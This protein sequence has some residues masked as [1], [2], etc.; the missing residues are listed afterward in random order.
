MKKIA[1]IFLALAMSFALVTPAFAANLSSAEQ[2]VFDK[3]KTEL[4]TWKDRAQLDDKHINQY[5]TEAQS[6]LTALDLSDE[7]CNEF[8]GAIDKI[9]NLLDKA[10]PT[11]RHE[12]WQHYT[13]I[14]NII[15]EIGAK[16]YNLHV[17]VDANT[18]KATVTYDTGG[19]PSTA[20]TTNRTVKQTGFGLGQTIA[21]A[22]VSL[23]VLGGAYVVARKKQLFNA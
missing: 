1:A 18:K 23:A 12:L 11:T 20:A 13:E 19:K 14:A 4:A 16:Y 2:K 21:V 6:A 5:I 8:S 3:F 15:N 7:A 22:G 9:H 17:T 10:N